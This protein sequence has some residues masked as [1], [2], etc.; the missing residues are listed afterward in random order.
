[1][2]FPAATYERNMAHVANGGQGVD[3]FFPNTTLVML[4]PTNIT[5]FMSQTGQI[6]VDAHDPSATWFMLHPV[7]QHGGSH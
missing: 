3:D 5:W 2:I 4:Q 7:A 1:M 6:R